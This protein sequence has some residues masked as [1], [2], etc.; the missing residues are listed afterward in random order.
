MNNEIQ[1]KMWIDDTIKDLSTAET[2]A[3]A[4]AILIS[5]AVAMLISSGHS[6]DEISLCLINTLNNLSGAIKQRRAAQ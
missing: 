2:V 3:D 6:I 4:S 1:L 5:G